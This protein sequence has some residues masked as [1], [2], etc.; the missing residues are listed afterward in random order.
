M[1]NKF[2][3]VCIGIGVVLFAAGFFIRSF[4]V[5]NAE[6]APA[7]ITQ[8]GTNNI[9]K[10]MMCSNGSSFVLVWDTETGKSAIYALKQDAKDFYKKTEGQLPV[11]PLGN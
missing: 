2:L 9:G 11:N 4:S 3:S 5:A 6:P 8:Q 1:Q 10:Y 7:N